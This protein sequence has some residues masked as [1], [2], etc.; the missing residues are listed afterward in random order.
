MGRA[1]PAGGGQVGGG[2][3]VGAGPA[4]EPAGFFAVGGGG[5]GAP[6]V[7]VGLLAVFQGE[8]VGV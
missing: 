2:E 5:V 7:E 4:D 3:F 6:A 8:L 1:V